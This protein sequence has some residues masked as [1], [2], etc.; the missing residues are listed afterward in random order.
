MRVL[1]KCVF[2]LCLAAA[3]LGGSLGAVFGACGPFTDVTDGFFCPFVL[4]IF[5][6]GITTGTTPTTYDP[7]GTVTRLQMA[8]FLSRTVDTA[9]KRGGPRAAVGKSWAPQNSSALALTTVPIGPTLMRSDG[10]D[11]WVASFTGKI[12]R[13]RAKDG[14]LLDT[15]TGSTNA[16]GVLI[17]MGRVL[18]TG[19]TNP[20]SLYL[21][22][23]T[24][25]AGGVTLAAT[26]GAQPTGI[27][28]DGSR[29]WTANFAPG[30]V[31]IVTPSASIPWSATTVTTGFQDLAGALYD[32]S[33]VWVTDY[34]AN[35]LLKL[36]A[37]G[38]V[39]QT[40]TVGVAP[41][42]PI[43]DGSNIWVPNTGNTL[44][45]VRAA[46][47]AVLATLTGN[48]LDSPTAAAF[49]GQR[50]LITNNTGDSVSLWKA[51]DLTPMGS[52][53]TGPGT[54]PIGACADG[55]NF[56][57]GLNSGF[58]IARF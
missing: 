55:I 13:V 17:A 3:L 50:V 52:L 25:P 44:T 2:A 15:W 49:D 12:S 6:L 56:W 18:A 37:T 7:A 33:N 26:V 34:A 20:G 32:G 28:F 35:T 19:Y 58:A 53:S 1:K 10:A 16:Y 24:K 42:Y 14:K 36:A 51:A 45:V 11:V 23:P 40:V 47:G 9:L 46:S 43:F 27:T 31:S 5:Y 8:A 38:A 54:Q 39:L 4:E 21:L 29:V 22:D 41:N 57:I 30:A 48:G